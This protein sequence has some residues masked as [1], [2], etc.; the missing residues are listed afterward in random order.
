M[1]LNFLEIV[2]IGAQGQSISGACGEAENLQ[3][4]Y[5]CRGIYMSTRRRV[6]SFRMPMM[7]VMETRQL[8]AADLQVSM[9][10]VVADTA[11]NEVRA[12]SQVIVAVATSNETSQLDVDGDSQ[13]SQSDFQLVLEHIT[14]RAL[15]LKSSPAV[16]ASGEGD[17]NQSQNVVNLDVTGDGFVTPR[18]ALVI[19]SQLNF[20]NTL[21]PCKCASC[22][23]SAG[24][25]GQSDCVRK[26]S[27]AVN[28]TAET[29]TTLAPNWQP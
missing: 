29:L 27:T 16:T 6:R 14:E 11:P 12:C 17:S 9:M 15:S 26:P 5:I 28:P 4:G 24:E 19:A 22:M 23:G 20:Y 10:P 25:G 2:T 3:V 21:V 1:F 18:D 7:E 13:I 8:M